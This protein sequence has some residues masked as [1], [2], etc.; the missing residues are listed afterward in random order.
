[1][2]SAKLTDKTNKKI[3]NVLEK[4]KMNPK[5]LTTDYSKCLE[6][7]RKIILH[8][9]METSPMLGKRDN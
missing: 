6:Y 8:I 5:S 4:I 2:S 3:N 9:N 1:M 7:K